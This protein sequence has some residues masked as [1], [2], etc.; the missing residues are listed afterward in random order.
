PTT[1]GPWKTGHP[2]T[3]GAATGCALCAARGVSVDARAV[4][5]PSQAIPE[6]PRRAPRRW[7]RRLLTAPALAQGAARARETPG[8]EK[9]RLRERPTSRR[10]HSEMDGSFGGW[11]RSNVARRALVDSRRDA[12]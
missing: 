6:A 2:E 8:P 4:G 5:A 7:R 12:R 9:R 1:S 10:A 11:P 3:T